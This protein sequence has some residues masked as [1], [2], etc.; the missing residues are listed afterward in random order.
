L[1]NTSS[2]RWTIKRVP[3]EYVGMF[4]G[5]L[6]LIFAVGLL[7]LQNRDLILF[8]SQ[9]SDLYENLRVV[10]NTFIQAIKTA[11]AA[12]RYARSRQPEDF[13][14]YQA[15]V[16]EAS[17]LLN[18]SEVQVRAGTMEKISLDESDIFQNVLRELH[19]TLNEVAKI[20]G[21]IPALG[22]STMTTIESDDLNDNSI[23]ILLDKFYELHDT[24]LAAVDRLRVLRSRTLDRTLARNNF[25]TMT[26]IAFSILLFLLSFLV[27]RNKMQTIARYSLELK[28][29][30]KKAQ[31]AEKIKSEFL[32]NMSHEIRTPMTAIL[33]FSELLRGG[34]KDARYASY[35]MG[36]ENS[37]RALLELI[38]D[39]LDLSKIEAGR[40]IIRPR[41]FSLAKFV[42][43][44][45]L[46]FRQMAKTKGLEFS[47]DIAPGLPEIMI[48]DDTRLRQILTNLL[49]NALK[50]TQS[51]SVRL[52]V[53]P[54][55]AVMAD[56][57]S[58]QF[59]VLDTGIGISPEDQR[60]IF[61]AFRQV[62]GQAS[63]NFGGTGLGLSIS[64]QLAQLMNGSISVHSEEQKG[65][66]F[67]LLLP[68]KEAFESQRECDTSGQSA[69]DLDMV[70]T[71]VHLTAGCVL[72]VEDDP[73]NRIILREFLSDQNVQVITANDAVQA[74]SIM[75]D[76]KIDAL[77]TDVMMPRM[78]GFELISTMR[79]SE[80]LAGIPVIIASASTPS[81]Q[82]ENM[83]E[84]QGFLKKPF[85][86]A[87][88]LESL[89]NFLP[90]DHRPHEQNTVDIHNT[91]DRSARLPLELQSM[92]DQSHEML[93]K[94]YAD[95]LRILSITLSMDG[96]AE[97]GRDLI[98]E[99]KQLGH[100]GLVHFGQE[101]E[102][103]SET[104]SIE[105]INRLL[106]QFNSF[107]RKSDHETT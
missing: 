84:V 61:D 2:K 98:M 59:S 8:E 27:L 10:D 50:F 33:G 104:L 39:I 53:T 82:Y 7:V 44:L 18:L 77:M 24:K 105:D 21:P 17:S 54:A 37:G 94:K 103:A 25:R 58:I 19:N 47:I 26:G 66:T 31:R 63:R 43:A 106:D 4:I 86:K 107:L 28:E 79:R 34:V 40:I 89:S 90:H 46:V 67:I 72:I 22:N 29:E 92:N 5:F 76:E 85:R 38:N 49:G 70:G 69:P 48:L 51:G 81:E 71:A 36:I 78:S 68:M 73:Q 95:R 75:Q 55:P 91:L 6:L 3:V 20:I 62:D 96:I 35:L 99:G 102:A 80:R 65:S 1:P 23:S 11:G 74:L 9:T 97:F 88:L 93:S 87:D 12:R 101:L 60:I 15:D 100:Q 41:K 32:A 52:H 16:D 57:P 45:D 64:L 30:T 14:L 42:S 83:P 13:R 56:T